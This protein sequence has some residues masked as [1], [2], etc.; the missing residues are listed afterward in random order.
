MFPPNV[1]HDAEKQ[2]GQRGKR[3][4]RLQ[5]PGSGD[6]QKQPHSNEQPS[7]SGGT[8]RRD[9]Q[10]VPSVPNQKDRDERDNFGV[11]VVGLG[12]P[13]LPCPNPSRE[14]SIRKKFYEAEKINQ[15]CNDREKKRSR[16]WIA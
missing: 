15:R 2:E 10:F 13:R 9:F 8:D 1:K 12:I 4:S 5:G 11:L 14:A 16:Q 6:E 3:Q 7:P